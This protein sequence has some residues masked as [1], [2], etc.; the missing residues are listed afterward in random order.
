MTIARCGAPLRNCGDQ[1]GQGGLLFDPRELPQV[2][3][4]VLD[5]TQPLVTGE[6][7]LDV[8]Q[9]DEAAG[10]RVADRV[11]GVSAGA[12]L[13]QHLLDRLADLDP[14]QVRE[15]THHVADQELAELEAVHQQARL[16]R[17]ELAVQ[18]TCEQ[19]A[20]QLLGGMHSVASARGFDAH[21]AHDRIGG[22]VENVDERIHEPVEHVE[23]QRRPE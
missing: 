5:V 10:V 6:Q 17:T 19:D 13:R 20:A 8:Q 4:Q 22:A 18:M 21:A 1:L 23:R 3:V 14:L 11:A 16:D 12:H 15:R 7:I 2:R 9:A